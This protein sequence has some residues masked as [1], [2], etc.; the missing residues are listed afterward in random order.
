MACSA[1][2]GI[3]ST[4]L[5]SWNEV[6]T[7]PYRYKDLPL[8]AQLAFTIYDYGGPPAAT[9]AVP[10]G[11]TTIRLFGKKS[12]LKK[13]KQRMFLWPD[14]EA[15]VSNDS[16]T[17]SKIPGEPK[18]ERGR[19]EKVHDTISQS[20]RRT[21]TATADRKAKTQG[22]THNRLARQAGIPSD[23]AHTCSAYGI[24]AYHGTG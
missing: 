3:L 10:V 14:K 9:S 24:S 22:H 6:I 1:L 13:G 7:L 15:D 12:T 21:D 17:P 19:L 16:S 23:R 11:G 4:F 2:I 8:S 5:S 20:H 18:D